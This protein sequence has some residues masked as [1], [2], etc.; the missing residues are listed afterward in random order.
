MNEQMFSETF[1]RM[2]GHGPM[3]WQLALYRDY[4]RVGMVP[5]QCDIPTG[6]GKTSVLAI[7]LIAWA[8][9][10]EDG[11]AAKLPRR[12]AYVVN[13]RTVVDQTTA[14]A[15]SLRD[16]V[17]EGILPGLHDLSISTLRGQFAD[18]RQWSADPSKPAIV[19]GT[20]DMI[21]SRLLFS[22]YRIGFKTRPMHA[23]L[24]GQDTLVVHDEAHLEPAFQQTVERIIEQ[25]KHDGDP[26]PLRL[27][28]L[29]ATQRNGQPVHAAKPR[30]V[31]PLTEE[32][33]NPHTPL[34]GRDTEPIHVAWRRLSAKKALRCHEVSSE[35]D[36]PER[37]R[38]LTKGHEGSG[39]A[40][41]VFV[42]SLDDIESVRKSLT[43]GK[44]GESVDEDRIETL[45]GTMRGY[46]RDA[47]ASD[48]EV[49]ARFLPPGD[50]QCGT[51]D[52]TVY[53]I[54]TAAGE[55]GVNLS[56]DHMVCDLTT[57]ES[58]AQRLGRVNRFGDR[59][60]TRVDVVGPA[61]EAFDEK[62]PLTPAR[63]ATLEL[64]QELPLHGDGGARDASPLALSRLDAGQRVRAFSPLPLIPETTDILFDAWA[65]TSVRGELPGRPP[66][67]PYLHG[68]AEWDPPETYVAWRDELDHMQTG[69]L[70]VDDP[71]ELFDLFPLEPHELLRER[72]DR[73][74]KEF[75]KLA[76]RHGHHHAWLVDARGRV[77]ASV[78]LE[79]LADRSRK[80]RI[81]NMTVILPPSIGG[82]SPQGML[83]GGSDEA[84][85]KSCDPLHAEP[86]RLRL[87]SNDP[88]YAGQAQGFR[89]V[90]RFEWC[91]G[92]EEEARV[93]WDWLK[94]LP[95]EDTLTAASPVALH[96]HVE[97][98]G[99]RL[100]GYLSALGLPSDVEEALGLAASLHDRGKHRAAFQ[101]L[102]GNTD[103][104]DRVLA[105]SGGAAAAFGDTRY[106]HEFGSLLDAD[107]DPSVQ[108]LTEETR[109]LVLHFIATH[110]GRARPHFD[111][112]EVFDPGP[113]HSATACET[114]AHET[115]RRYARLQRRFG[116]WG[117]AYYESLLRAADYA[118]SAEPSR[119]EEAA[120]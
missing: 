102:L 114:A 87:L 67:A 32:E 44:K 7:W 72:S 81:E 89:L 40:V 18:N 97:D 75:E 78:T 5:D 38:E 95:V 14:E 92:E 19:C 48:N 29:T 94:R 88:R 49:F 86:Q 77:E 30:T 112:D 52:G 54:C 56:A 12:L 70:V 33:L 76:K 22:G 11:A 16:K 23:G 110:H 46:E 79:D 82:L 45:T 104:P 108:G 100:K 13:R 117:L 20:V 36:A 60:E 90:R 10:A 96:T 26:Y 51:K 37:I 83:D 64:L 93:T 31:L 35:K 116:R 2:T 8:S 101:R 111:R 66:V 55:V 21:G 63:R 105:K 71:Q 74:F 24:L 80:D 3:P 6:L 17:A 43:K 103:F 25:Q 113:D 119:V 68:I 15:E 57:F 41:L 42:Q 61:G 115:A 69:D 98:V 47:L 1:K 65:M 58:M 27:M 109:D 118:A 53:L 34:P 62:H 28:A 73:A 107:Q 85:D 9:G 59:D 84:S 120:T 50:R 99:E 91:N 106:R 4:F 39:D